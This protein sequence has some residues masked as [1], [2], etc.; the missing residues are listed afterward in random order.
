MPSFI[1]DVFGV[2]LMSGVYG[3]VL[4]AWA[5][6][7]IVGPQI[8]AALRDHFKSDLLIAS[9]WSFVVAGAF[10]VVGLGLSLLLSNAPLL[11]GDTRMSSRSS[12][13]KE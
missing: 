8:F 12:A 6:A 2:R 13:T 11:P 7:G 10:A 4:T 1:G 5:A 9:R 3:S